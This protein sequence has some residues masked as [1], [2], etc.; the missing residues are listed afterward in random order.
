M[1]QAAAPDPFS[2][3]G[4]GEAQGLG[5]PGEPD[6]FDTGADGSTPMNSLGTPSQPRS[7][8]SAPSPYQSAYDEAANYGAATYG[9]SGTAAAPD[10]YAE[11]GAA[12]G[13]A[14]QNPQSADPY[15][16]TAE[17]SR[18]YGA[19]N[20]GRENTYE[21]TDSELRGEQGSFP[22]YPYGGQSAQAGT[23]YSGQGLQQTGYYRS[24]YG[25][26]VTSS[27][28]A[29][30]S[31]VLGISSWLVWVTGP[32]AIG[33][34]VAGLKQVRREPTRYGGSGMAVAGIVLGS[35]STLMMIGFV[36]MMVVGILAA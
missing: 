5:A 7:Q 20:Y 26:P 6:K 18:G 12:A 33:F 9:S 8:S 32:L 24:P 35:L 10:P 25:A 22:T 30:A 3:Q 14:T 34:G 15:A 16:V 27:G 4:A 31:L 23:G 29:I 19:H 28:N 13:Y 36:L 17:G 2:R 11:R 1:S 21:P